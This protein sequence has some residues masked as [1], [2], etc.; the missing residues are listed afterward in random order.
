M[1]VSRLDAATDLLACLQRLEGQVSVV[2]DDEAVPAGA[3]AHVAHILLEG[4]PELGSVF[5]DAEGA[6]DR[7][8]Q[9]QTE[10]ELRVPPHLEQGPAGAHDHG[11]DPAVAE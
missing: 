10:L 7:N 4:L 8:T 11:C 5:A 9:V 3:L 6:S 1:Q 2:F